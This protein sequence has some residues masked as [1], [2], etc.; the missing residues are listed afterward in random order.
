MIK[1]IGLTS[2]FILFAGILIYGAVNR[3]TAKT[4]TAY[5]TDEQNQAVNGHNSNSDDLKTLDSEGSFGQQDR[6]GSNQGQ[7]NQGQ[8]NQGQ[9]NQEQGVGNSQLDTDN[10]EYN[11][12]GQ[13]RNQQREVSEIQEQ[14]SI[15]GVVVHAP[16][17]G[18]DMILET[19]EGEA[20]IGTGSGYLADQ[21]FVVLIGDSVS[22]TGF[23]ENEEFKAVEITQLADGKSIILRDERGRPMW[24]R[25][26]RNAMNMQISQNG[27]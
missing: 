6:Q 4:E 2:L 20:L 1:K 18:V 19:A 24:S 16:S 25:A 21:G 17:E 10:S 15:T 5:R 26:G 13:G 23:W 9:G 8:G 11:G 12:Q 7:G 14:K 3:T 27:G 22:V